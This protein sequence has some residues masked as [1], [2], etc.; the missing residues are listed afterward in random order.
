MA[1]P[2]HLASQAGAKVLADHGNAVDAAVAANLVLAVVAPYRCG[3][4]GD[5][6]AII[7]NGDEIVGYRGCG[8]SARAATIESVRRALGP[9]ARMPGYGPHTVTVPGAVRGWF[10]LLERF[11]TRSFG[12][13]AGDAA[14]FGRDGFTVSA[15]AASVIERSK[16]HQ[17]PAWQAIYGSTAEGDV[18]RQPG[19]ARTLETLGD[20]G[21]EPFYSGRIA[22]AIVEAVQAEGGPLSLDDLRRHRGAWVAPLSTVYRD[23]EILELPPPSQGVG[24]LEALRIVE[25]CGPLPAAPIDRYHLLIEAVK[26]A[27]ADL[28]SW[29]ADPETMQMAAGDLLADSWIEDRRSQLRME[30][31]AQH[32]TGPASP[33]GTAYLT[34]ADAQGQMISLIQSNYMD[35][36]SGIT[37]G[38]WGINLHNRGRDFVLDPGAANALR[39]ARYPRHTLSPGLIR[40]DGRPWACFGT[41]GGDYQ[42]PIGVQL[43]GALVD[44]GKEPGEALRADRWVIGPGTWTVGTEPG[45][46]GSAAEG[47]RARG[48]AVTGVS[49][50]AVGHAQIIRADGAGYAAA[51]DPR[52]ESA[53]DG[54]PA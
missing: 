13:L 17:G 16:A 54:I 23:A 28:R 15:E 11:G 9:D 40:K 44:G 31:A 42:V 30:Q 47:L 25:S 53:V 51:A 36:G 46:D 4:G 7:T 52:T 29:V 21:P 32:P 33:G 38:A 24:V 39:P 19:A 8:R 34:A 41:R 43:V 12:D 6:M 27:Q 18:L 45:F 2:H 14:T 20:E 49:V 22:D 5:L 48:H 50:E 10:D 3:I 26:A 35:F 37:A 1:T